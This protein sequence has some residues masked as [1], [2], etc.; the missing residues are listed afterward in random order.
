MVQPFIELGKKGEGENSLWQKK[1][2]S[3]ILD[4]F[5]LAFFSGI[6]VRY[7]VSCWMNKFRVQEEDKTKDVHLGVLN[8]HI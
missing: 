1:V 4:V 2:K 5:N 7:D 6:N 3:L 8:A